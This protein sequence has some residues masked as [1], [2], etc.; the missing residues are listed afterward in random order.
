MR[1]QNHIF[2][3]ASGVLAGML[4]MQACLPA[5][6]A[7]AAETPAV[8]ADAVIGTEYAMGLDLSGKVW[9]WGEHRLADLDMDYTDYSPTPVRMSDGTHLDGIAAIAGGSNFMLALEVTE[10]DQTVWAWGKT[11]R[12]N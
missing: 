12:S 1:M 8:L 6:S 4:L 5:S 9:S 3:L 10:T 2:K 7:S 11:I